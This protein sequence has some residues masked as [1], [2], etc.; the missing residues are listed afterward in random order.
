MFSFGNTKLSKNI[1]I[2]N[3]YPA[4]NCPSNALGLC[5]LKDP[6]MC[7][8]RKA[9]RQYQVVLDFR[10]RQEEFWQ[11][12]KSKQFVKQLNLEKKNKPIKF[13]RFNESGDFK[14]QGDVDRA[15]KIAALLKKQGIVTYTYTSRHDLNFLNRK[16]LVITGTE[17]MLDNMFHIVYDKS[18]DLIKPICQKSCGDCTMCMTKKHNII[19]IRKH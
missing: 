12:C 6:S 18:Q 7:Y 15:I 16:D 4:F 14:N 8:A 11:S 19:S 13:L 2:F 10:K 1:A 17:F 9:E 5:K 3:M